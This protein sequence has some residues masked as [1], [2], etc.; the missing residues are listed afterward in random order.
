MEIMHPLVNNTLKVLERIVTVVLVAGL[1][2]LPI[3]I[4][5]MPVCVRSDYD[6]AKG[7]W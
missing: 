4:A 2:V 6:V 7:V 3:C 5:L 1:L